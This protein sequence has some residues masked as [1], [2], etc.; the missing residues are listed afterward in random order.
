VLR[1]HSIFDAIWT[2]AILLTLLCAVADAQNPLEPSLS[3]SDR[4]AAQEAALAELREEVRRQSQVIERLPP[5]DAPAV[6]PEPEDPDD[7]LGATAGDTKPDVDDRLEVIEKDWKGVIEKHRKDLEEAAKR[8]TLQISGQVQ[9]DWVNFNQDEVSRESVGDLQDAADFR[10]AR[11]IARGRS[12][13]VIEYAFGVDFALAGRPSFLDMYVEIRDLPYLQHVRIGHFFEPFSLERVTQNRNNTFMERSLVDTFAP[14]RNM[15]IMAFG[16]ANDEMNSWQIGTFR[17]GSNDTGNDSFDSGNALTMRGTWLPYWDEPSGGRH[18]LHLGACYSYRDTYQDQVR[19]RNSP[20]IR[21][22][23][24]GT[25]NN[26]GPIFVDTGN[27]PASHFQLFDS[28]VAWINGPF[29]IQSEYAFSTVAQTGGPDLFL[30]GFMVQ[31]SYF[32][33]GEHRPYSKLM[34]I[35]ERVIPFTNFFRVQTQNQGIQMGSGAWELA[36]RYSWIN[37]TNKNVLGNDLKDFTFGLNWYLN[38]YTRMK[39]NYIRAYLDDAID[40]RSA[41]NIFG[42]RFDFDF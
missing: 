26:F 12:W 40:G 35:H 13:E 42:M 33:T 6:D 7:R 8:P 23:L 11:I 21:I 20:E 10:R 3:L 22:E 1:T 16:N 36:A 38:P 18:Y 14:A 17:T 41:T 29:S 31:L 34:G 28:E 24:P 5:A 32:L 39:F 2:L 37:L 27:I 25:P 19:F 9:G 15:G 30:D 4:I